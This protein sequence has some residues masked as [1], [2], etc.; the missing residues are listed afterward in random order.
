MEGVS[1]VGVARRVLLSTSGELVLT[2][3]LRE[4]AT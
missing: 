3:L 2:S 1:V 4:E